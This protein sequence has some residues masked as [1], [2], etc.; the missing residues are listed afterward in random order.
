MRCLV[1]FCWLLL[2]GGLSR[3]SEE[4]TLS[5]YERLVKGRAVMLDIV[6]EDEKVSSFANVTAA[7]EALVVE[8]GESEEV[9]LARVIFGEGNEDLCLELLEF[10]R[11]AA[12]FALYGHPFAPRFWYGRRDLESLRALAMTLRAPCSPLRRDRCSAEELR[13]LEAYE[14]LSEAD[15]D[16]LA[17]TTLIGVREE[18][19]EVFA[20]VD[21]KRAEIMQKVEAHLVVA[22]DKA[23]QTQAHLSLARAAAQEKNILGGPRKSFLLLGHST[24]GEH[25]NIDE[26]FWNR[27]HQASYSDDDLLDIDDDLYYYGSD[28]DPY[29]V[30]P[31]SL[32]NKEL[33]GTYYGEEEN[34]PSYED[35]EARY[36]GK[37]RAAASS[38]LG[39]YYYDDDS[40]SSAADKH[41]TTFDYYAL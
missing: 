24:A 25:Y 18:I 1:W 35:D 36:D 7:W 27:G 15:I 11:P 9:F 14:S 39:D 10:A 38:L 40:S 22:E 30:D 23:R 4:L 37:H 13:S 34:D 29:F 20:G 33:L 12:R 19:Q 32:E 2:G 3:K 26:T 16:E 17:K 41:R 6:V 8:F 31:E 28:D 21:D 5:N